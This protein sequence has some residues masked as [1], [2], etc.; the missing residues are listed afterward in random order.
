MYDKEKAKAYRENQKQKDRH[1]RMYN[2]AMG[3]HDL[4]K[5]LGKL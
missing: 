1:R 5:T 4:L 3:S 2:L